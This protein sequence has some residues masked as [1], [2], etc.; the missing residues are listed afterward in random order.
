M[1]CRRVAGVVGTGIHPRIRRTVQG[2]GDDCGNIEKAQSAVKESQGRDLVGG[3]EYDRGRTARLQ[4][5]MAVL[6]VR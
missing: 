1:Y 6:G 5:C 2:V 3:V 4:R